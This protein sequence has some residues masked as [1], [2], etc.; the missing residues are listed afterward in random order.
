M[1]NDNFD[2]DSDERDFIENISWDTDSD[3]EDL[4]NDDNV[5]NVLIKKW[6]D[7]KFYTETK[8]F[9]SL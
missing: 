1:L 8:D 3:E 2:I 5:Y 9:L 4:R 7:D 6:K